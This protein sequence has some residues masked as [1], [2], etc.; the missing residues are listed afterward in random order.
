[1]MLTTDASGTFPLIGSNAISCAGICKQRNLQY[2]PHLTQG[3]LRN[4][5]LSWKILQN[6]KADLAGVKTMVTKPNCMLD[7][8]EYR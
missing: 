3:S 2:I 7:L 5:V 6:S 4:V 1:M 8:Q